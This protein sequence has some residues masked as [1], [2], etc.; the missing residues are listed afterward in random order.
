MNTKTNHSFQKIALLL[1]CILFIGSLA[2]NFKQLERNKEIL[3]I[4][5]VSPKEKLKIINQLESLKVSYTNA[6]EEK[7]TISNQLIDEKN[8]VTDLIIKLKQT[9]ND[10]LQ[11]LEYK[12]LYLQLNE[13]MKVLLKEVAELKNQNTS[14]TVERDDVQKKFE[15]AV[16]ENDQLSIKN[17]ELNKTVLKASKLIITNLKA[18]AFKVSSQGKQT[19]TER[20]KRANII[21]INFSLTENKIVK[22]GDKV[23][24][25]QIMDDKS[26]VLGDKKIINY[27]NSNLTYTA[28]KII[29]YKNETVSTFLDVPVTKLNSGTYFINV[30]YRGE[31]I[32]KTSV[33]LN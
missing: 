26:D 31:L 9:T 30:F 19:E 25:I 1:I 17:D 27:R 11:L 21:K 28:S 18:S 8:K 33:D 29:N 22:S 5:A 24:F 14:L 15:N 13:K 32:S 16:N 2:Y 10:N 23:F 3:K 4:V 12:K 7:T 6:I 20:A